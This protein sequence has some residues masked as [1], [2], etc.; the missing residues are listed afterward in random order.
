MKLFV[1]IVVASDVA[2]HRHSFLLRDAPP[3]VFCL[4][5]L[6]SLRVRFLLVAGDELL[7]ICLDCPMYFSFSFVR[8]VVA[9]T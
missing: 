6:S 7:R 1:F 3:T 2:L 5:L 9:G 8:L 4:R